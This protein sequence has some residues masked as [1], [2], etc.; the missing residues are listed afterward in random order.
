MVKKWV[1]LYKAHR[2]ILESDIIHTS[3]RRADGRDIDWM[4]HANP[5]LKEK[6]F[7]MIFNPTQAAIRKDIRIS[8]YYTGLTTEAQLIDENGMSTTL[9]L[10]RDYTVTLHVD[11]PAGEE[12]YFAVK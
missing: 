6:G 10:D 1:D 4:F 5:N 2:D 3:S 9:R 7:L 12:I 11:V 8:L